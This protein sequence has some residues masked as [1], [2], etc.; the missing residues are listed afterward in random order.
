MVPTVFD[1]VGRN[2]QSSSHSLRRDTVLLPGPQWR[3][4]QVIG[5]NSKSGVWVLKV[6]F[7][8]CSSL[9]KQQVRARKVVLGVRCF[10]AQIRS[11]L[12]YT[13]TITEVE[14]KGASPWFIWTLNHDDSRI[15]RE[16]GI[17]NYNT[18]SRQQIANNLYSDNWKF[19]T[20]N[21]RKCP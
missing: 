6:Y 3:R 15:Y 19:T 12:V 9:F 10:M 2:S 8:P 18:E 13:K 14:P 16:V 1:S 17:L 20:S 4:M 7:R 21:W 11:L 5:K